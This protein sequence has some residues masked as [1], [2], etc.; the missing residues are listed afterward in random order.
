[1]T[2]RDLYQSIGEVSDAFLL[3]CESRSSRLSPRF[4]LIAA[5]IALMLTACAPAAIQTFTALKNG[6]INKTDIQYKGKDMY[7][8]NAQFEISP[9]APTSIEEIYLPTGMLEYTQGSS[10]TLKDW[11]FSLRCYA[12]GGRESELFFLQNAFS[13]EERSGNP[14]LVQELYFDE[15]DPPEILQKTYGEIQ[16]W[17]YLY[18]LHNL[19][20]P[21]I[22]EDPYTFRNILWSDGIYFYFFQ[23]P[24]DWTEEQISQMLSSLSLL[25][26]GVDALPEE[27]VDETLM[28]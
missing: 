6:T 17:E 3:E 16:A 13:E 22:P 8:V 5:V 25:E 11:A 26:G 14:L 27:V 23:F 4:A 21:S 18:D 1:M 7:V 20:G 9:D 28:Q 12:G 10:Y 15:N 19:G 2:N 24:V